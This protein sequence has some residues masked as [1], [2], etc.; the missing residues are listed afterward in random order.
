MQNKAPFKRQAYSCP[1]NIEIF[2]CL[3]CRIVGIPVFFGAG[4]ADLHE[5]KLEMFFLRFVLGLE[6]LGLE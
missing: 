1:R 2:L 4:I 3:T 6:G 5:S